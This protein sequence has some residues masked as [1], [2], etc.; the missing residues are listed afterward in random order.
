MNPSVI[1]RE[2]D[3]SNN[4]QKIDTILRYTAF[5][6]N[7]LEK[8]KICTSEMTFFCTSKTVSNIG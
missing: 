3:R 7:S 5:L 2:N 8:Q 4:W 6:Q 1:D